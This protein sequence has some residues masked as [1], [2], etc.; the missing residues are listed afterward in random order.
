[1]GVPQEVIAKKVSQ[2]SK[3]GVLA[4]RECGLK[5][6][7][8]GA[9]DIEAGAASLRTVELSV[10][11]LRVLPDSIVAWEGLNNLSCCS[12]ELTELPRVIGCLTSLLKLTVSRNRLSSLPLELG[13]L[14]R[15]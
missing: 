2:A 4:L 10:N 12:N 5:A 3:T 14:G 1:M 6:L 15:L 7:P 8:E 11:R 9:T 13:S